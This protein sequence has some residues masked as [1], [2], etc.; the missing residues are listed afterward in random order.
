MPAKKDISARVKFEAYR[1]G[2]L[3]V[4]A[5]AGGMLYLFGGIVSSTGLKG[6]P[7]V[8]VLEAL[9]PV[10]A[11]QAHP[12]VD[13]HTA[14]V[15]FISH[16]AFPL[17]AGSVMTALGIAALTIVLLFL[18]D[19]ISFRRPEVW[20]GA[21]RLLLA[22]GIGLAVFSILRQIV[23]AV[24]THDFAVGHDFSTHAVDSAL[25]TGTVNLT[26]GYLDLFAGFMLAGAI[27]I[28]MLNAMRVGLVTRWFGIAGI[29]TAVLIA[30]PIF[31]PTLQIVPAFWMAATGLLFAG[32]WPNGDPPAWVTGE[33]RPW[34]SQAEAR[35]AKRGEV[36]ATPVLAGADGSPAPA[37]PGQGG[38]SRKRRRKRGSRG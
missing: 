20:A 4:P 13:P 5:F 25:R 35:A 31:G 12:A 37:L 23:I 27:V 11:G 29:V 19:S 21:R 16:N 15:K 28:L 7:T 8:G 33:A 10:L 18:L 3:A 1:R 38:S 34:P 30:L 17:I 6:L 14:E 2:R 9:G 24:Q 22:G 36:I 32:R 26:T